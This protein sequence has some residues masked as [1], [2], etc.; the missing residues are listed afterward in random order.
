MGRILT[1]KMVKETRLTPE[2]SRRKN[3]YAAWSTPSGMLAGAK[4]AGAAGSVIG[5]LPNPFR[6]TQDLSEKGLKSSSQLLQQAAEKR[7]QMT[8]GDRYNRASEMEASRR[9]EFAGQVDSGREQVQQ[10]GGAELSRMEGAAGEQARQAGAGLGTPQEIAVIEK[11]RRLG[12]ERGPQAEDFTVLYEN[13]R[14]PD[15]R[16]QVDQ[17]T[18]ESFFSTVSKEGG[19]QGLLQEGV[20]GDIVNAAQEIAQRELS[21]RARGPAKMAEEIIDVQTGE[22]DSGEAVAFDETIIERD[23]RYRTLVG[24]TPEQARSKILI[25]ARVA[26]T[27]ESQN[28]LRKMWEVLDPPREKISDLFKSTEQVARDHRKELEDRMAKLVKPGPGI[29][30][31]DIAQTRLYEE[32]SLSVSDKRKRDNRGKRAGKRTGK[33]H[34][35]MEWD[36]LLGQIIDDTPNDFPQLKTARGQAKAL[37]ARVKAGGLSD[38]DMASAKSD[39]AKRNLLVGKLD[40][41]VTSYRAAQTN[42]R[43][44]IRA[45]RAMKTKTRDDRAAKASAHAKLNADLVQYHV[46]QRVFERKVLRAVRASETNAGQGG[47]DSGETGATAAALKILQDGAALRK[48]RKKY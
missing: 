40:R 38:N 13:L 32:K 1:G 22:I 28:T 27:K 46:D 21:R 33:G 43:S 30:A 35:L 41:I 48:R 8:L 11:R 12:A 36:K 24:L 25:A 34:S 26:D 45:V 5:A 47:G 44:R 2:E 31:K 15:K 29:S 23:P 10:L 4:L 7:A 37:E 20:S 18:L 16:E 39:L 14:D 42:F 19:K 17:A 6:D 9:K 3:P